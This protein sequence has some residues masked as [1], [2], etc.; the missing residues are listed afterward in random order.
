ML[1]SMG[2]KTEWTASERRLSTGHG[3]FDLLTPVSTSVQQQ[4]SPGMEARPA[5]CTAHWTI[6]LD[7]LLHWALHRSL[8]ECNTLVTAL[9]HWTGYCTAHCT[10]TKLVQYTGHCTGH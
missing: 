9:M 4:Q 7:R 5:L 6:A 1:L 3:H 10:V 8:N 2:S